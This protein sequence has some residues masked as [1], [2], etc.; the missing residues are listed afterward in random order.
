MGEIYGDIINKKY[1][2]LIAD[3]FRLYRKN[4]KNLV[5]TWL[6]FE[7]L[8]NL[9][10]ILLVDELENVYSYNNLPRVLYLLHKYIITGILG[11]IGIIQVCSV[12]T[13]L[14]KKYTLVDTEFMEEFKQSINYRLKY[15]IFIS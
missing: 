9:L 6:V 14:F 15:P 8:Y 1:S 7:L 11:L 5:L 13:F 3:G 2:T 12:S 10:Y 4:F